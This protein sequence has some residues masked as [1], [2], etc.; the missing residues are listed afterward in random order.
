MNS[1]VPIIE[2]FLS[3]ISLWWAFICFA[4]NELF[5]NFP[6][7]FKIF[8]KIADE[9]AWGFVFV[10][11][12]SIKVLGILLRKKWLRKLGLTMSMLLYGIISSSF[13]LSES[14][15]SISAGTY[16]AMTVLAIWGIREVK[17]SDA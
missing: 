4:N 15:L 16:F 13:F 8:V 3:I 1:R 12:A 14:P 2:L 7:L 10:S 5:D 6:G 11:A 9:K 17:F